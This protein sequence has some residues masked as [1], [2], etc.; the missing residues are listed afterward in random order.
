MKFR[1]PH[2]SLTEVSKRVEG[3]DHSAHCRSPVFGATTERVVL[4]ESV[5]QSQRDELTVRLRAITG[6]S[7]LD[8]DDEGALQLSNTNPVTG[9]MTARR[10]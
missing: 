10:C 7:E 3:D 1:Q 4:R 6:W 5:S 9:S 2:Q 8:F